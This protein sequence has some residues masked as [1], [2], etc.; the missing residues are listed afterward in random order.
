M[1]FLKRTAA[2]HK[3]AAPIPMLNSEFRSSHWETSKPQNDPTTAP[4]IPITIELKYM[5]ANQSSKPMKVVIAPMP[6]NVSGCAST[7]T[8]SILINN[9]YTQ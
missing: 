5:P 4:S 1:M 9:S 8:V 6:S 2:I 7:Q 3:T